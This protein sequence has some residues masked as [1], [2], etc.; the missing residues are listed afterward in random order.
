VSESWDDR[1]DRFWASATDSAPELAMAGMRRLVEERPE[2]DPDAIYEWAS[3]HDFLGLETDAIPLYRLALASGLSGAR[4][5]QAVIQLASS[6]RNTGR[7]REAVELL[8]GGTTDAV[9]GSAAQAFLALALYDVGRPRDAL[10]VALKALAPTLPLYG[11]AVSSY[12][13]DLVEE[14]GPVAGG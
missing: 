13:D 9:T 8:E 11:R 4:H 7:A 2:T 1:V 14:R 3:V 6:L 10:R 5:P 12:A